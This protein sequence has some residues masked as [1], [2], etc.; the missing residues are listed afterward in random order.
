MI[1]HITLKKTHTNGLNF[2]ANSK[3]TYFAGISGLFPQ[4]KIFS[5][6]VPF[7]HFL[8][9]RHQNVIYNFIKTVWVVFENEWL[10]VDLLTDWLTDRLTDW[11]TGWLI[12]WLADWLAPRLTDRQT[13]CLGGET[14]APP[15]RLRARLQ[16]D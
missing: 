16:K 6:K 2:S 12:D 3:K 8:P 13:D 9:L 11:L 14:I 15:F 7:C 1:H 5:Q 4:K 10:L